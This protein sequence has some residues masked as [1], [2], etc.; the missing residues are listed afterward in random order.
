[1]QPW[2]QHGAQ[3]VVQKF[4]GGTTENW[5]GARRCSARSRMVWRAPADCCGDEGAVAVVGQGDVVEEGALPPARIGH[6]VR[7]L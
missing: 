4:K 6:V 2:C 7:Q 5:T 3:T 1:M